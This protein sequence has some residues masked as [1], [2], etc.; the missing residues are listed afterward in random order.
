MSWKPEF[1]VQ[2][3]WCGNAQAFETEKE[4]KSSAY[5]RFMVWTMP[6]DYRA[7]EST[8]PVN[9]KWDDEQGNVMLETK[10]ETK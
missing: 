3:A 10:A 4:A 6:E 2:G 7:V 5:A 1:L 9:Y 8:E